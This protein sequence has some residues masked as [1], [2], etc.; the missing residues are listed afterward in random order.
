M[1]QAGLAVVL[2]GIAAWILVAGDA[3]NGTDGTV[4]GPSPAFS[5]DMTVA[6]RSVVKLAGF[7]YEVARSGAASRSWRAPRPR[8]V[9][10]H[11]GDREP[12][13]L[14]RHTIA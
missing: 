6:R 13:H 12:S 9:R 1:G 14:T 3:L 7:D 2:F 10:S 4:D 11:Q 5:E 8:W